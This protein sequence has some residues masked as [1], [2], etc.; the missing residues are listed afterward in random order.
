MYNKKNFRLSTLCSL[1]LVFFTSNVLALA[2]ALTTPE[3]GYEPNRFGFAIDLEGRDLTLRPG[4]GFAH[5]SLNPTYFCSKNQEDFRQVD[6]TKSSGGNDSPFT[7]TVPSACSGTYYYYI[8][9]NKQSAI[10][11]DPG[12]LYESTALFVENGQRVDAK[13]YSSVSSSASNWI[14]IR[15]P[16]A[17]DGVHEAVV[18]S[19]SNN[20][21]VSQLARYTM[22]ASDKADDLT[23]RFSFDDA[24]EVRTL[25]MLEQGKRNTSPLFYFIH[26][27]EDSSLKS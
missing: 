14:R 24:S 25:S 9:F 6:M 2:P 26:D 5:A 27:C 17:H 4:A 10:N 21:S 23:I 15:H 12:S 16:H 3:P 8:R 20:L 11:N 18:D 1:S 22:S 13:S 19:T 7:V